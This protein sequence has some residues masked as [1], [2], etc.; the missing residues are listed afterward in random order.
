MSTATTVPVP[1]TLMDHHDPE[2]FDELLAALK[3]VAETGAFTGGGAVEAF[4]SDYARWCEAPHAIGVSSG[5]EALILALRALGVGPGDEVVVPANSFIAT[6]EAVT[7]TG[8][9]PRF[10]DVD[11]DTQLMSAATLERSLGPQVRCVIPVHLFGRTVEMDPIL[12]LARGAGL[13][14][15]EDT[16]QAH[17]ARY[18][19][20]RVGTLGDAGTFSFY[21]AKNLGAWGDAG[22]VV[23]TRDDLAERVRLL[24]SHGESPRYHH[25]VVGTTGR[26][27]AIQAAVLQLKLTRLEGWNVARRSAA[28]A[29]RERLSGIEQLTL[30]PPAAEGCDHV[31]HQFVVRTP[32]RDRLRELLAERGIA[33]GI[34]YPIPIHR[35]QAYADIAPADRDVAPDATAL[36][37]EILS[38]PIYPAMTIEQIDSVGRAV[39]DCLSSAQDRPPHPTS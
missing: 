24:R 18:R 30:P 34:H 29:L 35:S 36:A 4:E 12:E 23:T 20:R 1:M 19:G 3:G 11:P 14:V 25:R 39:R 27:D 28:D 9:R 7:L 31:Y 21:P 26:L 37:K 15:L 32:L 38:L 10:A 5:T 2:L 33:S 6:A 17:G 13:T 16:S 22:A 8:A